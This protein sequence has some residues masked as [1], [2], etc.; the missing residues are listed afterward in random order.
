MADDALTVIFL[1]RTFPPSTGGMQ[2]FSYHLHDQ[3]AERDDIELV[4]KTYGGSKK[5]LPVVLPYFLMW[6]LYGL[7]RNDIDCLY[8]TDGVLSPIGASLQLLTG[9][10]TV[11]TVHGLDITFD[12]WVYQRFVVPTL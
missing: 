4:A 5:W 7:I 8:M 2:Q 1:S 12:N 3:L 6:A 10:P 11:I 9:T